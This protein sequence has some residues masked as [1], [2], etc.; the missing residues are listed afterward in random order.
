MDTIQELQNF[1]TELIQEINL[2]IDGMIQQ[3]RTE[4]SP[5]ERVAEVRE[6][7]SV[8]P[9][10]A[11]TGIFKGKKPTGVRFPD[12]TRVDVPTWKKVVEAILKKCDADASNHRVLLELRGKVTGRDRVLLAEKPDEMRSP[13][14]ISAG[15]YVETHYDTETLLK[16]ITTRIL[17]AVHYD[18]SGITI[19]VRNERI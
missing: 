3:L 2:R 6:Y 17:D 10:T 12:G 16:I 11:S 1:R 15:I 19:A 4:Q 7:E 14:E 9:L 13:L 18:Y 8:Y 5:V